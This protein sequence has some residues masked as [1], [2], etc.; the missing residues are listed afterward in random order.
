MSRLLFFL[1]VFCV[2][3]IFARERQIKNINVPQP[4]DN[5]AYTIYNDTEIPNP[6]NS[7]NQVAAG[8]MNTGSGF[9]TMRVTENSTNV[10]IDSCRNGYGWLNPGIRSIDMNPDNG[11]VLLAYRD[12]KVGDEAT[13]ILGCT[14]IDIMNGLASGNFFSYT[15]LNADI[16]AGTVGARYPGAVA[17]DLPFIHFNQY[18]EAVTADGPHLSHP[19]LISDYLE[20]YG[21][22]GGD[23]TESWQMDEGIDI[24]GTGNDDNALWN[25]P[26]DI[27]KDA[28]GTYHFLGA[29]RDWTSWEYVMVNAEN[30][31]P[32][33]DFWT[34]DSDPARIDTSNNFFLYPTVSMNK[35]GFAVAAGIGHDGYHPGNTFWMDE[36]RIMIMTSNDYGKTWTDPV[37]LNWDDI[38][39]KT[40]VA[41]EDSIFVPDPNDTSAVI[42][43]TG[44]IL[45]WI[46]S[47]NSIDVQVSEENDVYVGFDLRGGPMASDSTYYPRWQWFGPYMAVSEDGGQAFQA[48]HVFVNNAFLAT[49]FPPGVEDQFHTNSEIDFALDEDGVLY[50]A[51]RDQ[52]DTLLEP[53]EKLRYGRTNE[54]IGYKTEIFASRSFDKGETWEWPIN[55][56]ASPGLDEYE[57]SMSRE[58][59]PGTDGTTDASLYMTYCLVDPNSEFFEGG[60][61]VYTDRVNRIWV[62]EAN[63]ITTALE[64][65][66]QAG[67]L[68]SFK[69][70]QNYPNPFNPSTRINFQAARHGRAVLDVF[71]VTGEKVQTIFNGQV[72]AG[73]VYEFDFDGGELAA[74]VYFYRLNVD[75]N[76]QT[77]KMVLIK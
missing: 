77:K 35:S 33:Y 63:F 67:A 51:W 22:D 45:V 43:Y 62:A 12:Y 23:W 39:I 53:A 4:I 38:G 41:E 74:G 56:T 72:Q 28:S 36:L 15:D 32:L 17:L 65:D 57:L 18:L 75:G 42:S 16:S 46:P 59:K 11:F 50:A 54:R 29:Y 31:D 21:N 47:N 48:H 3:S 24:N 6:I 26:V 73:G 76:I 70:E 40:S 66:L 71:S 52:P 64:D 2:T 1:L 34:I 49:E 10:L 14:S 5:K 7:D 60:S 55:V 13:G 58:A 19:Y 68:K 69:L 9:V 27:V 20:G 37:Q 44:K 61:D 30:S 8:E 25:G